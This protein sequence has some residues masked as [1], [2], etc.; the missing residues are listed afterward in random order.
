MILCV[1]SVAR[2][3]DQSSAVIDRLH[4]VVNR[5]IQFQYC[6][7]VVAFRCTKRPQ[8]L[9]RIEVDPRGHACQKVHPR[10]FAGDEPQRIARAALVAVKIHQH[11]ALEDVHFRFLIAD[12]LHRK[13]GPHVDHSRPRRIDAKT[14][15]RFGNMGR[16]LAVFQPHARFIDQ[17]K[18]RRRLHNEHRTGLVFNLKKPLLQFVE[19]LPQFGAF[20][21]SRFALRAVRKLSPHSPA[22]YRNV[23]SAAGQSRAIGAQ[24]Y[25]NP[26]ATNSE[27]ATANVAP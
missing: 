18:R 20:S 17:F 23:V 24:K 6:V 22:Q 15:R 5:R 13:V 8:E 4:A 14:N 11:F 10:G 2:G 12:R 27:A 25:Q 26:D 19:S 1:G 3:V 21:R 16:H 9:L 7:G